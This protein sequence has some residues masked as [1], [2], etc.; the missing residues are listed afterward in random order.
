MTSLP[1]RDPADPQT[2][3][4]RAILLSVGFALAVV[5]ISAGTIALGAT[6]DAVVQVRPKQLV[7][8]DWV[9]NQWVMYEP[10]RV[11]EDIGNRTLAVERDDSEQLTVQSEMAHTRSA[12]G[13]HQLAEAA[14]AAAR[15]PWQGGGFLRFGVAALLGAV[16][17]LV[18]LA[19][20][21]KT[22]F[23]RARS[24]Q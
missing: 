24:G 13:Y 14:Q 9:G 21:T 2:V 22:D 20:F 23:L 5:L 3:S 19:L 1:G 11:R 4:W 17:L 18:W 6:G 8:P 15:S 10:T 16:G 12:G 7:P